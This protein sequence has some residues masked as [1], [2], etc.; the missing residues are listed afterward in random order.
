MLQNVFF[1]LQSVT[2]SPCVRFLSDSSPTLRRVSFVSAFFATFV[3]LQLYAGYGP[4]D[5]NKAELLQVLWT[6]VKVAVGYLIGYVTNNPGAV[7]AVSDFL[8][9]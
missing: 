5:K 3:C 4:M 2:F 9:Y 7:Q 1:L 6:L 8:N